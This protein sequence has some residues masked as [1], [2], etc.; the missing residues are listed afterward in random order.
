MAAPWTPADIP[1]LTGVTA[2]VT[3]A[4]SGLGLHTSIELA[5]HGAR[6]LMGCRDQAKGERALLEVRDAAQH[7]GPELVRL[8]LADLSAVREAAAGLS[9]RFGQLDLLVN[10]AGVMAVPR[11]ESADGFELQLATNHLGPF[12]LTNLLL[13]NL[14]AGSVLGGAARVVT[15]TSLVHKVGRLRYDD[16]MLNSSYSPWKAY[17][18]SKLAN[19]LFA[20]ELQRR[21]DDAGLELASLAAHPGYAATNLQSVGPAMSGNSLAGTLTQLGNRL[22][23]QPAEQGAWPS[24]RAASDP[25]A[26]GGDFFGPDGFLEQRGHPVRVARSRAAL[27]VEDARWLWER[28]T[29]L[30]GV[31]SVL[32]PGP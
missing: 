24:L 15:V 27:N 22:F 3:G 20:G 2:L 12:A 11:R 31:S 6:V 17:A 18:Q 28:S 29:Q 32:T 30:T 23:A 19:L 5:R 9:E 1:D 8:D 7:A 21:A 10:N 4:N 14:G 13:P 26:R 16:L 25:T